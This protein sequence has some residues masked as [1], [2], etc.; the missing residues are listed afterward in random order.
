MLWEN[1]AY[2]VDDEKRRAAYL[3]LK[4]RI[5][6]DA[7]K[8]RA[9]SPEALLAIA[10]MGGMHPAQR[11]ERLRDVADLVCVEFGGH[12]ERALSLPPKEA[13]KA[14][15]KFPGIGEP[16]AEKI[17]LFSGTEAVLALE[18]NGLRTL[19]RLGFGVVAKNY[20]QRYK[21]AKAAAD[22]Q[23][24]KTVPARQRAFHLLRAHGQA[25]CKN[26]APDCDACPLA[27]S[28]A[29]ARADA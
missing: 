24:A 20:S 18:S 4:K 21:S 1:V 25:L 11:A 16:G 8:I 10:S 26:S 7:K 14:L 2:L 5:G 17:L 15:K 28:C 29:F 27:D 19:L 23:I 12:L 6:L 13:R 9:A 22:A 3:A